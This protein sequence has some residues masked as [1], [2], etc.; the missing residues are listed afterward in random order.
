[1]HRIFAIA[2]A[3]SLLTV[4]VAL[5][6][7]AGKAAKAPDDKYLEPFPAHH[8]AGNIYFVG[9]KGQANYLITTPQGNILINSG[10]EGDVPLI[11]DSIAKL[12]FKYGDTRILLISHAHFDHDAGS[13]QVVKDTGARYEV[14]DSDVPVVHSGG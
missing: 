1:M 2:A 9:T 3:L 4:P 10:V 8:V 11:K 14:L 13:A 6:Q 12:G 5:A 7:P